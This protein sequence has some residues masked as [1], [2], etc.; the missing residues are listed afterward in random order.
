M[1]EAVAK[2]VL[3]TKKRNN[4]AQQLLQHE[5]RADCRPG[6]RRNA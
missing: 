6:R 4:R 2:V 5:T 3:K 1:M